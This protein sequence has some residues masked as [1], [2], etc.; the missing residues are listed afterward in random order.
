MLSVYR[1]TINVCATTKEMLFSIDV[2]YYV[3]FCSFV[4]TPQRVAAAS[5]IHVLYYVMFYVDPRKI[6]C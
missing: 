5:G 1:R 2:L 4:W 3:M 6:I